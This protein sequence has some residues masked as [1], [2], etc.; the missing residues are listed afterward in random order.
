MSCSI[1]ETADAA[2]ESPLV[3]TTPIAE[4]YRQHVD[5]FGKV[6]YLLTGDSERAE[7]L[8]QEAFARLAARL[9]HIRDPLAVRAYLR[10]TIVNLAINDCR[11]RDSERAYLRRWGHTHAQAATQPDIETRHHLVAALR[12]LP[13]RQR[14]V[15]VLRYYE[16]LSEKEIAATLG[17]PI[18]TVKSS[19]SRA[20]QTMRVDLEEGEGDE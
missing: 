10:K 1:E 7:D 4:L 5:Y 12:A 18:G 20:L 16:D 17:C 13:A 9:G 8:V 15:V 11:R 2:P 19:L 14:A 6:A 3:H